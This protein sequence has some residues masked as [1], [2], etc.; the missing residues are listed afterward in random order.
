MDITSSRT[1]VTPNCKSVHFIVTEW[2][3]KNGGADLLTDDL[4]VSDD[5]R[6]GDILICLNVGGKE[7]NL[8]LPSMQR[9][10]VAEALIESRLSD[11]L[12]ATQMKPC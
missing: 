3:R 9:S 10:T 7:R 6:S 1:C 11:E 5:P 12:V 4:N 8:R 2:L